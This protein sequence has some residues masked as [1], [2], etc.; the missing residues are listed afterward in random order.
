M[1]LDALGSYI[2]ED[3]TQK[4]ND[5]KDANKKLSDKLDSVTK[6]RDDL[7]QQ[8]ESA[9]RNLEA[10]PTGL[11]AIMQNP[12]TLKMVADATMPHLAQSAAPLFKALAGLLDPS[13]KHP[14]MN[15]LSGVPEPLQVEFVNMVSRLGNTPEKL[16]ENIAKINRALMGPAEQN[17][18]QQQPKPRANWR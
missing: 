12:D 7:K 17:N 8:Y 10:K 1:Q 14:L 9:Q 6:E 5:L 4:V 11:G 18:Q 3:L 13:T 16:T 15:W 2:K